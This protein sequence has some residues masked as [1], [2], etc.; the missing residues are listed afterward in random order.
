MSDHIIKLTDEQLDA[1]INDA[2]LVRLF[3]ESMMDPSN[4]GVDPIARGGNKYARAF[5]KALHTAQKLSDYVRI[6]RDN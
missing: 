5:T 2:A 6:W 4:A 3:L 1:L